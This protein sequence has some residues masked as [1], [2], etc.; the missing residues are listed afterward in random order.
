MASQQFSAQLYLE[1]HD[2]KTE[3]PSLWDNVKYMEKICKIW[4]DQSEQKGVMALPLKEFL[5]LFHG[6]IMLQKFIAKFYNTN[7][8]IYIKVWGKFT[9]ILVILLTTGRTE[10]M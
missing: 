10:N 1:A 7:S 6:S 3:T 5:S 8:W 9:A 2:P 4:A